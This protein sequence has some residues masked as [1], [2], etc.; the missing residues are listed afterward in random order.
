MAAGTESLQQQGLLL[1]LNE[2]HKQTNDRP[3]DR[4]TNCSYKEEK[5]LFKVF[6]EAQDQTA[7]GIEEEKEQHLEQI[8][9][10]KSHSRQ[11]CYPTPSHTHLSS[12]PST[13]TQTTTLLP[14]LYLTPQLED[15][16][17]S[18]LVLLPI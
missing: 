5:L 17:P 11:R 2:P 15:L 7:D 4:P 3:T 10:N 6:P 9:S 1:L 12:F 13:Q 8:H 18:C 16:F 14:S